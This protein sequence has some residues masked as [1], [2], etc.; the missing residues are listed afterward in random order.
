MTGFS[1]ILQALNIA[2]AGKEG[3]AFSSIVLVHSSRT[4]GDVALFKDLAAALAPILKST[5]YML[6]C[7]R[8][9]L[10]CTELNQRQKR[11][12]FIFFSCAAIIICTELNLLVVTEP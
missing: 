1:P 9:I 11:M 6:I 10:I 8:Y 2:L 3:G 4:V 12:F 7:T 5:R